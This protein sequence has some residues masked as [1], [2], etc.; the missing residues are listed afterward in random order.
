[1]GEENNGER[2]RW[3]KSRNMY[4]GPTDKDNEV[5]IVFGREDWKGEGTATGE[6]WGQL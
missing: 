2:R 4:Q 3:V 6:K 1:M 5:G